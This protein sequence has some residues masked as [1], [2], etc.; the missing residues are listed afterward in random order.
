[1]DEIVTEKPDPVSTDATGTENPDPALVV[2]TWTEKPEPETE[3]AMVGF[4]LPLLT[5]SGA[6]L[7]VNPVMTPFTTVT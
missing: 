7:N 6:V 5:H 1:M 4:P 3:N 2:A